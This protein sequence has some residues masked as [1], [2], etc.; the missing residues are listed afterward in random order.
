MKSCLSGQLQAQLLCIDWWRVELSVKTWRRMGDIRYISMYCTEW[1]EWQSSHF[2]R[3]VTVEGTPSSYRKTGWL[4]PTAGI[5]WGAKR[6]ITGVWRLE[7]TSSKP[8]INKLEKK[9]SRIIELS[10]IEMCIGCWGLRVLENWLLRRRFGSNREEVKGGWRKLHNEKL[11]DFYCSRGI[12]R[13]IESR[14]MRW[15]GLVAC[16]G[17]R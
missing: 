1:A 10:R 17:R 11:H 6:V 14:R 4:D 3:F 13:V 8:Q 15:T 9:T 16:M 5:D 7:S 12:S 2:G